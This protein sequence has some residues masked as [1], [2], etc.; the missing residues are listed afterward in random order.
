MTL[1]ILLGIL[2]AS[3]LTSCIGVDKL[4]SEVQMHKHFAI[5][6]KTVLGEIVSHCTLVCY[7]E[8]SVMQRQIVVWIRVLIRLET[9]KCLFRARTKRGSCRT[10]RIESNVLKSSHLMDALLRKRLKYRNKEYRKL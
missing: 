9:K 4:Y 5:Y 6:C 7:P 10:F 3:Q 1:A 8:R 2:A